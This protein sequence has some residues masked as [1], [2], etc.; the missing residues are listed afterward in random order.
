LCQFC[1]KVLQ[2]STNIFFVIPQPQAQAIL[3][4]F[5]LCKSVKMLVLSLRQNG[6]RR[7][8]SLLSS[9][10]RAFQRMVLWQ[11]P[12]L[13]DINADSEGL[14]AEISDDSTSPKRIDSLWKVGAHVSAAGGMENTVTN[15]ASIGSVMHRWSCYQTFDSLARAN[16]FGLFLKSPLQ[17]KSPSLTPQSISEFKERMK[18]YGYAN[19]MVLSNSSYLIHLGNPD[20]FVLA[21][22]Y[23]LA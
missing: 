10:N 5:K 4:F 8:E 1:T 20:R 16:S 19:N 21:P 6:F 14:E 7:I 17:W 9:P 15:A 12:A 2:R 11:T 18:Q 13:S 22:V 3:K 23:A